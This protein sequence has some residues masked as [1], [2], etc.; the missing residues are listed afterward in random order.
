M[1]R[2]FIYSDK[3]SNDLLKFL[4][5]AVTIQKKGFPGARKIFYYEIKIKI[6]RLKKIFLFNL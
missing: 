3:Q 1:I 5:V 2:S 6:S 4:K